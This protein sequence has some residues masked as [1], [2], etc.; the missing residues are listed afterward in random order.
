MIKNKHLSQSIS[1]ASWST[2]INYLKYKCMWLGKHLIEIGK[3][4]P[5][6]QICSN[7]SGRQ[8][9]PLNIRIFKCATCKIELNRDLNASKNILAAG[10]TVLKPIEG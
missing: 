1:D 8:K 5:T 3:F 7:C 4:I 10:M 2:F 6:S 9:M